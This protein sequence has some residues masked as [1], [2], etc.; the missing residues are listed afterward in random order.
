MVALLS[1]QAQETLDASLNP[2]MYR[3]HIDAPRCIDCTT[4]DGTGAHECRDELFLA[5]QL[6][7]TEMVAGSA[8]VRPVSMLH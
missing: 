8:N 6:S 7:K 4:R 2:P 1:P 5:V 3:Y